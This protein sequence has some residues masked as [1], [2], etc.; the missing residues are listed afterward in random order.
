MEL[1]RDVGMMMRHEYDTMLSFAL[2]LRST[3]QLQAGS[4]ELARTPK[5]N[6]TCWRVCKWAV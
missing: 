2:A 1:I 3:G 6:V 5:M 4:P